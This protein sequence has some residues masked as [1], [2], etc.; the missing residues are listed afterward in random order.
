MCSSD[1]SCVTL[2]TWFMSHWPVYAN[3]NQVIWTA[4]VFGFGVALCWVPMS[5]LTFQ[6][7][8]PERRTEGVVLFNLILNMGSGFGITM[9]VLV[10]TKSVQINHESLIPHISHFNPIFQGG[11]LPRLWD[12]ESAVGLKA[13]DIEIVRQATTI[14]F[15]NSFLFI[16]FVALAAIP[17]IYCFRRRLPAA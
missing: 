1:L 16:A 17:V 15:G 12:L 10:F 2:A 4:F 9:A 13:M 7:T 14:A 6:S 8:A 11:F 5:M 3:N